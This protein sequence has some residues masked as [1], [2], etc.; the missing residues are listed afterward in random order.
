ME[1]RQIDLTQTNDAQALLT[2][3]SAYACDPKGGGEDLSLDVKTRLIDELKQQDIYVGFI[4][5]QGEEPIALANCFRGFSSFY[6]KPLLNIHDF[7]VMPGYRGQG[8]GQK[9]MAHINEYAAEQ[10]FCKV[11]L[12]VLSN[13]TAAKVVY[14]KAGFAQYKLGDDVAEFW[15]KPL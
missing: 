5:W 15:Q 13:N 9:L 11:T 2:L 8:I 4:V 7:A 10:G 1:I 6:A 12:E 14:S 3:L